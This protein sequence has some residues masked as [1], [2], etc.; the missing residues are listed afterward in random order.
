[1]FLSDPGSRPSLM[2]ERLWN[3]ALRDLEAARSLDPSRFGYLVANLAHQAAEKGLKV[4]CWR[5]R[6]EE[7][8]WSHNLRQVAGLLVERPE[9]IPPTVDADL[10]LL[11]PLFARSRYPSGRIDEPIPADLI[12]KNLSGRALLAAEE[13]MEWVRSLLVP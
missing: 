13:V 3:Q 8:P 4:A 2:G 7:P 9:S 1:M 6:Q 11:E 12:D 10:A 5:I